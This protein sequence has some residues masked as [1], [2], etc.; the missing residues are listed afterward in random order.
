[1]I[2]ST[3]SFP[4]LLARRQANDASINSENFVRLD[5]EFPTR[6]RETIL[7]SMTSILLNIRTVQWLQKKTLKVEPL[8]IFRLCLR[9]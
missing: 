3:V 2:L 8:E 9:F 5:T 6:V 1:M 4:G 7:D